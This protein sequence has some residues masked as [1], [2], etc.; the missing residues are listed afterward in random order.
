V[1][2]SAF[3]EF[4]ANHN[5]AQPLD[6]IVKNLCTFLCQDVEQTPTFSYTRQHTNG[7]L[8]LHAV[9]SLSQQNSKD[10]GK[11]KDKPD[12]GKPDESAKARLSRRGARLAFDQLAM[13]FGPRLL[14]ISRWRVDS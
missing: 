9:D 10:N 12:G 5:I 7:I 1:A 8:S 2:I 3:I 14:D 4:C 11:P 6:K 13:K